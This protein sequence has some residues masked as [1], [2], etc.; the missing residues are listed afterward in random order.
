LKPLPFSIIQHTVNFAFQ[1]NQA[2][3]AVPFGHLV[4]VNSEYEIVYQ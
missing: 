2:T 1:I 3:T 4:L